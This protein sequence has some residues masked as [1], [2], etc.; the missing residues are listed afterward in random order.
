MESGLNKQQIIGLLT[1][2]PHGEFAK[3]IPHASP[4]A[5]LEPEFFSH[6]IAWNEKNGSIRDSKVALPIIG[7]SQP[8]V[9]DDAE[10]RDNAL[11][12]LALLSPRDL[13]RAVRF[14][15]ERKDK[16]G[17]RMLPG[18][19]KRS[20]ADLAEQYLR[21]REGRSEYSFLR[22]VM[23]HRAALKGLYALLHIKPSALANRVLFKG[24]RVGV[25]KTVGEL[26]KMTP[27]SAATA[28]LKERIPFLIAKAAMGS[29]LDVDVVLALIEAATPAEL[30][31]NSKTLM[32]MGVGTNPALRGAYDAKLSQV[33]KASP[34]KVATL[35]GS[36]A[37]TVLK[38]AG[39]EKAAAKIS[40]ETERA[41]DA[42]L[43]M[44]GNWLVL[45]DKSG[46]MEQAIEASR[47]VAAILARAAKG[48]VHLV[49]FD[50]VPDHKVVTGKTLEQIQEITKRVKAGGGTSIG[51]G[52]RQMKEKGIVVDAIA[53]IT[54]GGET[55]H[56]E[57][58]TAY[59][60]Y[61]AWAG[62]EVPVYV[63]LMRGSSP[64]VM[65]R[66]CH[67]MGIELSKFDLTGGVDYYSLP[68]LVRTMRTQRY[69][70]V[71]DI[72]GTPLLKL[73]DVLGY[74]TAKA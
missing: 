39:M 60:E 64:D 62:K 37:A 4:A 46:S 29:T 18:L 6:M 68:N 22:L 59:Q 74:S 25:L 15:L 57:F 69:S 27:R 72:M 12:H 13:L 2:S 34:T 31:N 63:Y 48:E 11:A 67:T 58:A 55:T 40:A 70:L 47:Q 9:R 28:I 66:N 10:L 32:K 16:T 65:T 8:S 30:L 3:Y 54:D 1:R 71:D 49:F 20:I 38:E 56:P 53:V 44:E 73:A 61:S 21:A 26:G 43:S 14:G 36:T 7:L 17:P 52:L 5:V 23:Q 33:A 19:S 35:K 51:C 45:G 50:N 24:E 42:N 41:I